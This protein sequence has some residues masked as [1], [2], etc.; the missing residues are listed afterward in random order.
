[1]DGTVHVPRPPFFRISSENG[2]YRTISGNA[3]G[4]EEVKSYYGKS[5]QVISLGALMNLQILQGDARN[6]FNVFN[7]NSIQ[8]NGNSEFWEVEE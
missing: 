1:M 8:E 4:K 2:P 5:F 3:H 7:G 6:P